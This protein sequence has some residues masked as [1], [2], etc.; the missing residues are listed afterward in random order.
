MNHADLYFIILVFV[1]FLSLIIVKIVIT[2]SS[3]ATFFFPADHERDPHLVLLYLEADQNL[4]AFTPLDGDAS[5]AVAAPEEK[6]AGAAC[7][8]PKKPCR[9]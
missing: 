5:E 8:I 4:A 9:S 6:S 3:R 1:C 2:S 7:F